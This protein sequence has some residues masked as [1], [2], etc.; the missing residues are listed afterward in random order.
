VFSF[1]DE[2]NFV[3]KDLIFFAV[4]AEGWPFL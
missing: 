4:S 2:S 1:E 3:F